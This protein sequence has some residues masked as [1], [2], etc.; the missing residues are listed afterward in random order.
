MEAS[1]N[2][3]TATVQ[4]LIGAAADLNLQEKVRIS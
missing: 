3:R 2:G 1:W 4:A